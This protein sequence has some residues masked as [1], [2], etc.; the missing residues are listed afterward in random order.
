[1]SARLPAGCWFSV[2][3]LAAAC[4]GPASPA[5]S[6]HVETAKSA[7]V[8]C[9][10]ASAAFGVLTGTVT[11]TLERCS[12]RARSWGSGS[13]EIYGEPFNTRTREVDDASSIRV[14]VGVGGTE[15]TVELPVEQGRFKLPLLPYR[16]LALRHEG[17]HDKVTVRFLAVQRGGQTVAPQTEPVAI[18]IDAFYAKEL[19]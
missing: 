12:Y 7:R 14:A 10:A 11:V 8:Q 9:A 15:H 16:E 17:E 3:W 18:G 13:V 19:R 2:L 1:M 6:K 4:Q 5:P